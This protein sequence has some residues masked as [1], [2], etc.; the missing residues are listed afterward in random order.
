MNTIKHPL[1]TKVSADF[2]IQP[3]RVWEAIT[4]PQMTEQYMYNCQLHADWKVGGKAVWKAQSSNGSW[5]DHVKAEIIILCPNEHLGFKVF[6]EATECHPEVC[7][8]LH[9]RIELFN[10]VTRLTIQQGDFQFITGGEDR[11]NSCQQ[12]W[13]FVFPKLIQLLKTD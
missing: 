7:S 4:L 1:W 9:Y 12:G 10:K 6:H 8:E 11:Y 3:D 13:D 5:H 2:K